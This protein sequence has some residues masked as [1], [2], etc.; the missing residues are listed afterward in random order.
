MPLPRKWGDMNIDVRSFD[1]GFL[2]EEPIAVVRYDE[3]KEIVWCNHAEV[4]EVTDTH[5]IYRPD[6][7]DISY[8]VKLIVCTKCGAHRNE[9]ENYWFNS[10][11]EGKTYDRF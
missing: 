7:P 4:E 1:L 10:P 11:V 2:T 6:L 3:D 5:D 8:T 9:Y